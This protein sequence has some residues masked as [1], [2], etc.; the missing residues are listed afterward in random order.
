MRFLLL[1]V[2]VGVM[3]CPPPA[4]AKF[5]LCNKAARAANVALGRFNGIDWMSE[6][7]WTITAG[8]CAELIPGPLLARYYYVYGSDADSGTWQGRT[9]FCTT[10]S[11][12]FSIV[13]R[14]SC[15]TRGYDHRE[16]FRIDTGKAPNWTQTLSD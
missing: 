13:G 10:P 6:G 7:W 4:W 9:S 15:A 3:L 11:N 8:K 12:R 5:T 2:F 1:I 14:Q 16:F